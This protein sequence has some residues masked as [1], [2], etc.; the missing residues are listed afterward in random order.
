VD[1]DNKL[2]NSL[3]IT[4]VK[5][6]TLDRRKLSRKQEENCTADW[7]LQLCYTVVKTG[8]LKEETPEE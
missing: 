7:P 6:N 4:G 5:N 3:K 8:P 2:S 1:V